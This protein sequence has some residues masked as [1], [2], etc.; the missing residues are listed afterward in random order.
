MYLLD[1]NVISE[2]R[3]CN[4]GRG[5]SNV[6]AWCEL[7][8]P[9][10][11]FISSVTLM[12]LR[13]GILLEKRR[14]PDNGIVLE[15]WLSIMVLRSFAGK[16]LSFDEN[17]AFVC[18]GYHVPDR[19]S[20]RDAMIASI[21]EA[22]GLIVVTRNIKDFKMVKVINPWDFARGNFCTY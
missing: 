12:E 2:I 17:A 8:D 22:N 20:E 14:N 19:K 9:N 7:T 11:M 4:D 5:D 3:K 16:I 18:A 15:N 21:A 13:I 1:T 10:E 6:R